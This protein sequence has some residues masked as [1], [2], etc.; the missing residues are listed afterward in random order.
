MASESAMAWALEAWAW[1]LARPHDIV[2]II[3]ERFD[4]QR[5]HWLETIRE[6]RAEIE[7]LR[8]EIE[9][10]ELRYGGNALKVT[11][12]LGVA[13]YPTHGKSLAALMQD[14]DQALYQAKGEGRNNVQTAKSR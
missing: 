4:V 5:D 13:V 3:A 14:V 10:Q 1:V 11:A 8:A 7:E 6:L 2:E 12:S 9:A